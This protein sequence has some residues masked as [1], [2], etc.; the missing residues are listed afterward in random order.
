MDNINPRVSGADIPMKPPFA[1]FTEVV[2][3][4]TA[5]EALDT[6]GFR[7]TPQ[8]TPEQVAAGV[9][10]DPSFKLAEKARTNR[11]LIATAKAQA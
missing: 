9:Q 4:P 10:A 1:V 5:T 8:L 11:D 3:P 7:P 2:S 6:F